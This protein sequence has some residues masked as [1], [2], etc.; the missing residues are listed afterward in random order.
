M[1]EKEMSIWLRVVFSDKTIIQ[2]SLSLEG[3]S[4][5]KF[6]I[7]ALVKSLLPTMLMVTPTQDVQVMI[8]GE[9][10]VPEG[11]CEQLNKLKG[12]A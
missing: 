6:E 11:L 12:G 5:P 4:L 7:A 10:I 8:E 3:S 1:G 9:H 2:G